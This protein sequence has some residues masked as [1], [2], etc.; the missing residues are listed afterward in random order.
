MNHN[1]KHINQTIGGT[2]LLKC[3]QNG[4]CLSIMSEA[5]AYFNVDRGLWYILRRLDG[6]CHF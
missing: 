4:L 1:N 3:I 2:R 6:R 5:D